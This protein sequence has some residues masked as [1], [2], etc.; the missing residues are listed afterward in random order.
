MKRQEKKEEEGEEVKEIDH[1][2]RS[3]TETIDAVEAAFV[4]CRAFVSIS[5]MEAS[6]ASFLDQTKRQRGTS[7]VQDPGSIL[8]VITSCPSINNAG[9]ACTCHVS[10]MA[11]RDRGHDGGLMVVSY[12]HAGKS[13]RPVIG[14]VR[15]MPI[16]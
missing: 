14:G 4:L 12:C 6:V 5:P 2:G 9:A 8:V 3:K 1:S 10:V 16:R 11:V 7:R 15:V 13:D